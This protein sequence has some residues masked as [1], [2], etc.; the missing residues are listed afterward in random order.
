MNKTKP[1]EFI[2]FHKLLMQNAPNNYSPWYFPVI[3]GNKAP[4]GY[5][6]K[7]SWKDEKAHLT[8]EQALDR[9]KNGKNV[10]LA[11][12]KD[13]PLVIIDIDEFN[14]TKFAPDTL[15]VKSRKRC[16]IHAF[17]F[18][19]SDFEKINIPT[20]DYGEV[21]AVDQYVV[22][23]GSYCITSE[24]D[25]LKENISDEMKNEILKDEFLGNYTLLSEKPCSFI[26]YNDLPFFYIEQ[27]E[28]VKEQEKMQRKN[29]TIKPTGKHSALFDL[30]ITDIVAGKIGKRFP[31]PLHS[32]D[33]G[34]NFSISN[35]LGHCWRHN[36][37]LNAIQFLCVESNYLSCQDAGTPHRHSGAGSSSII[38]DDGSI[39][40]AWRQ[41]KL[42]RLIPLDDPVPIRAVKYIAKKHNISNNDKLTPFEFNKALKIISEEY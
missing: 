8:F 31:H 23:C 13:D 5:D 4:D 6:C 30:T 28:K 3:S 16:A 19:N 10:G 24:K 2:K 1:E 35:G 18:K 26:S 15:I 40:W 39:F 33:T 42:N 22:A 38:G 7:G 25:I 12:R 34:M 9:L 29:E 21:R 36:V 37:S 20:E 14:Y 41:A 11:A 27:H 32:S 17:C